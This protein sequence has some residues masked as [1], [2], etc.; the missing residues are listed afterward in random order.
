MLCDQPLLTTGTLESLINAYTTT[1]CRIIASDY[2]DVTGVPAL[3]H[4]SLFPEML[5][6]IGVQGAKKILQ[7]YPHETQKIAFTGGDL[8]IDTAADYERLRGEP[9]TQ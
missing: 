1:S 6:V 2:G 5:G 4:K 8:D 9:S 7:R 3:F